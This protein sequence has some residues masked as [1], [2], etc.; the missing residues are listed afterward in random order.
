M[1]LYEDRIIP[2]RT[3]KVLVKRK[4]DLCGVESSREKWK[5][6]S[7]YDVAETKMIVMIKQTDGQSYPEGGFGKEY[8]IDLCP[9]C[10]KD[11]LVPWLISQ[12]ANI[13]QTDWEW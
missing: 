13:K 4:C 8:E 6:E 5:T 7:I 1:K 12:G 10:F 3:D 11:R 2:A 9:K